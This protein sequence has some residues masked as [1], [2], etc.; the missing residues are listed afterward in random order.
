MPCFS[1][2]VLLKKIFP[3]QKH[4]SCSTTLLYY[5][6]RLDEDAGG[7]ATRPHPQCYCHLGSDEYVRIKKLMN[8]TNVAVDMGRRNSSWSSPVSSTPLHFCIIPIMS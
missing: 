5:P 2:L 8:Q 6:W 3:K 1:D 4:L 7:G